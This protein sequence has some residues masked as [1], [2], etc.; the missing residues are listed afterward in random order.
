MKKK[1]EQ[2]VITRI[3]LDPAQ[4]MLVACAVGAAYFNGGGAVCMTGTGGTLCWSSVR[5]RRRGSA[6]TT[7]ST[8]TMPS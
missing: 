2:P 8:S 6:V 3:K 7:V 5:A 1:Y 4:A